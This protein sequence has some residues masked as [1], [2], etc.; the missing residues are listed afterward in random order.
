MALR[1]VEED[2]LKQAARP[3]YARSYNLDS[4]VFQ[5]HGFSTSMPVV[6]N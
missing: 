5:T 2:L 4:L 6:F 3:R 1:N